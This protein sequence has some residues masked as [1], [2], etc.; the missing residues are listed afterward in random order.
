MGKITEVGQKALRF[1]ITQAHKFQDPLG[2]LQNPADMLF[3]KEIKPEAPPPPPTILTD[4]TSTSSLSEAE[5]KRR[6]ALGR[7]STVSSGALSDTVT[8]KPTLLGQ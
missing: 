3:P 1:G 7:S 2:L 8:Y 5:K 6:A 4:T